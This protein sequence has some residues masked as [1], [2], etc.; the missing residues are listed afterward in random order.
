MSG[1]YTNYKLMMTHHTRR[2]RL[3]ICTFN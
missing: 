2:A 3:V 1:V